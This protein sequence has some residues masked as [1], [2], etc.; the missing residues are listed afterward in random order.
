MLCPK[1]TD[2]NLSLISYRLFWTERNARQGH[3]PCSNSRTR[4]VVAQCYRGLVYALWSTFFVAKLLQIT[5][6]VGAVVRRH[7]N[8]GSRHER[9][10]RLQDG[11]RL[12]QLT[13]AV[14]IVKH[15]R[16]STAGVGG[17][18]RGS[19]LRGPDHIIARVYASA[20]GL[21]HVG[22]RC[23]CMGCASKCMPE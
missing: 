17:L 2:V 20:V 18:V 3:H 16:T 4:Q 12:E 5:A 9:T 11:E 1:T 15:T 6:H 22:V 8:P 10:K 21:V 7:H 23:K 14:H 13:Q 19:C